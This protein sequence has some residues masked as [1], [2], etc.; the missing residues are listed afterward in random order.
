MN[1]HQTLEHRV[2]RTPE[3]RFAVVSPEG[4]TVGVVHS[5][6]GALMWAAAL[7]AE[8]V[9]AVSVTGRWDTNPAEG[10]R[11]EGEKEMAA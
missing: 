1:S 6:A 9:R 7:D 8:P 5:E 11:G 10:K 2:S 3:G 4:E